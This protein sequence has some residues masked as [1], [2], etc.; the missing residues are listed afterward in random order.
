M[1]LIL[2]SKADSEIQAAFNRYEDYQ[3]GR[4]ELFLRHVD[5]A[6]GLILRNPQIGP[7]YENPYRRMLVRD[8]PYGIFYQVQPK[9]IIIV[10]LMDL[11]QNPTLVRKSLG[12]K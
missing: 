1:E 12:I 8:F 2:L 3:A 10:A 7:V 11:R 9:R 5:V 6:I 4:G